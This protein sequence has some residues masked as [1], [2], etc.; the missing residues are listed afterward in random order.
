MAK[1]RRTLVFVRRNSDANVLALYLIHNGVNAMPING[2]LPQKEREEA[3][4]WFRQGRARVIVATDDAALDIEGL[5]HVISLDLPED[6]A[7]YVHRVGRV[8]EGLATSF[9]DPN[10]GNDQ[11][12]ASDLIEG[13]KSSSQKIP[14]FLTAAACGGMP[15]KASGVDDDWGGGGS[16]AA[17]MWPPKPA[18]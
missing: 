12:L 3:M 6:Y 14:E 1:L 7:T 8:H 4:L 9:F 16:V 5:D 10:S 15:V 18:Q 13:L 11:N 2:D 17:A